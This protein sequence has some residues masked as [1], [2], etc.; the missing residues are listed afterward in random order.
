ME[1]DAAIYSGYFKLQ[2]TIDEKII[3]DLHCLSIGRTSLNE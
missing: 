1:A 2:M 3:T